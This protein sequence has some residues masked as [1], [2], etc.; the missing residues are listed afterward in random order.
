MEKF[1][2]GDIVI[3]YLKKHPDFPACKLKDYLKIKT[4]NSKYYV[5][6]TSN[7]QISTLVK[8]TRNNPKFVRY[9]ER[10]LLLI[11]KINGN[12]KFNLNI[13]NKPDR[14]I[15]KILKKNKKKGGDKLICLPNDRHAQ[16]F[17]CIFNTAIKN[18]D[19][20]KIESYLDIGCGDCKKTEITGKLLGLKNKQIYGADI[21]NWY[22]YNNEKRN[23]LKINFK[24]YEKNGKLPFEDNSMSVV[25]IIMTLH[26]L[27]D[28]ELDTMLKEIY[29]I[30]KPNG[31]F[32]IRDH[33]AV[34]DFDYLLCDI[35]HSL[36]NDLRENSPD[37]YETYYGRYFDWLEWNYLIGKFNFKLLHKKMDQTRSF[38]Y[39]IGP[40]RSYYAVYQKK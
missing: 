30:V 11:Y 35:E 33:D 26:H 20:I 36:Y 34:T 9:F 1:N 7:K 4:Y 32:V 15:F 19:K 17:K 6:I 5:P 39:N 24:K 29:R 27:N 38:I 21:D 22:L 40:T 25:S 14:E 12:K 3:D 16:E 18:S 37:F 10:L 23:K 31:Y 28:E 8:N 2:Y 13:L